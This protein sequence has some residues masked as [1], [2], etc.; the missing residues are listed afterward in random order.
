MQSKNTIKKINVCSKKRKIRK[1]CLT[2]KTRLNH[3]KLTNF[4]LKIN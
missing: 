2:V 4:P 3:S 1:K